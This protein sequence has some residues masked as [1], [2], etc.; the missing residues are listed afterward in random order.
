MKH[1]ALLSIAFLFTTGLHAQPIVLQ[2]ARVLTATTPEHLDNASIVINNGKIT[3][4][5]SSVAIPADALVIDATGKTITPGFVIADTTLGLT[6]ISGGANATETASRKT[7]ISAGYDVQYAINPYSTAI[8]VARKGGVARAIVLPAGTAN[9]AFAGQ[10]A[11]FTL[12]S[13]LPADIAA[14]VGVIWDV[15]A[16]SFGRG[17]AFVQLQAELDDVRK[18]ARNKSALTKGELHARDWSVADLNALLP[19]VEGKVPLAVRANRATDI[20]HLIQISQQQKLRLILIGAA[21]G[22]QLATE[23]AN[24]NI[25]VILDPTDNLPGN[26][27]EIGVT[28]DNASI[29][30]QAGVTLI[31]RGGT[32]AHDAGK[33]RYFAGMAVARGVPYHHALQAITV[34]PARVWGATHFGTVAAGQ[35]ADL[36]IWSGDPFEPLTELTALY[37]N[38]QLQPLQS[39]QD[40]LEDKYI[41]ALPAVTVPEEN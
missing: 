20:A 8:A 27:E 35:N 1:L 29:L 24:A 28:A 18:Y 22:W 26:F 19:V 9:T 38:G 16:N 39:R 3:A 2:N 17:A 15:R 11:I 6:E 21:E 14:K 31:I 7:D 30:Q 41:R 4:V 12:T 36:A 25:P 23:L 34:N 40:L 10:A 37:I 33:L 13:N 32:S 5:G